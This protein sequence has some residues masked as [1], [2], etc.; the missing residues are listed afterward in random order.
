MVNFVKKIVSYYVTW[1]IET[2]IYYDNCTDQFTLAVPVPLQKKL[3]SEA[4]G[5]Q[6]KCD[7]ELSD[8]EEEKSKL[9]EELMSLKEK[10]RQKDRQILILEGRVSSSPRSSSLER[11]TSCEAKVTEIEEKMKVI[12]SALF[13]YLLT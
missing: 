10:L 2:H 3:Q 5:R 8:I 7:R 1:H 4:G 6:E 13:T 12:L 9:S 11:Q